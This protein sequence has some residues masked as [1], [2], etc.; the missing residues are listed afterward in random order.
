MIIL[1][2]EK[3]NVTEHQICILEWFLKDNVTLK[4]GVMKLK[5]QPW[6]A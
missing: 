5:N 2:V 4:I 1:K 6:R 3:R